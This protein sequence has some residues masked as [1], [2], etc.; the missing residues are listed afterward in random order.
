[1]SNDDH[2]VI[3]TQPLLDQVRKVPTATADK[4]SNLRTTN[5]TLDQQYMTSTHQY[6]YYRAVQYSPT[7]PEC[8]PSTWAYL[9]TY[10]QT[11]EL[12]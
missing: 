7:K 3:W 6:G 4:G 8:V 11:L 5:K 2:V 9:Y 10:V 1:M 12:M